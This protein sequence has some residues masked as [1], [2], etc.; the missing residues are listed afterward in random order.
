MHKKIKIIL[1]ICAALITISDNF[2]Y[3]IIIFFQVSGSSYSYSA[4]ILLACFAEWHMQ[5][6]SFLKNFWGES[7]LFAFR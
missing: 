7:L 6:P 5:G 4:G 2:C 1:S 3:F